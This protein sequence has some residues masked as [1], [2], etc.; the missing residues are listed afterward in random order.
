MR[1]TS[2]AL[3]SA[4]RLD[5]LGR[6]PLSRRQSKTLFHHAG[7]LLLSCNPAVA[8]GSAMGKQSSTHWRRATPHSRQSTPAVSSTFHFR[9]AARVPGLSVSAVQPSAYVARWKRARQLS[10]VSTLPLVCKDE[11]PRVDPQSTGS[12]LRCDLYQVVSRHHHRSQGCHDRAKLSTRLAQK[13]PSLHVAQATSISESYYSNLRVAAAPRETHRQTDYH[14]PGREEPNCSKRFGPR[15]RSA[16]CHQRLVPPA[17]VADQCHSTTIRSRE[18]CHTTTVHHG[19]IPDGVAVQPPIKSTRNARRHKTLATAKRLSSSNT[20]DA[21]GC[22]RSSSLHST[23]S[24]PSSIHTGWPSRSP[25]TALTGSQPSTGRWSFHRVRATGQLNKCGRSFWSVYCLLLFANSPVWNWSRCNPPG[26]FF[27]GGHATGTFGLNHSGDNNDTTSR[28]SVS[29]WRKGCLSNPSMWFSTARVYTLAGKTITHWVDPPASSSHV[30]PVLLPTSDTQSCTLPLASQHASSSEC[31]TFAPATAAHR[32]TGC[33][34]N[35]LFESCTST[36]ST[37]SYYSDWYS[38]MYCDG[39]IC[40]PE[41]S[42][43]FDDSSAGY[44]ADGMPTKSLN[45]S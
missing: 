43:N 34:V 35:S 40:K 39:R 18:S 15:G 22:G 5:S 10:Q 3:D 45:G 30:A 7:Q 32:R 28:L 21:A 23:S 25:S 17:A 27:L 11:A 16:G 37:Q 42:I 19:A 9:P 36:L 33:L 44:R 26:D 8:T 20:S 14:E 4:V 29:Q 12:S 41:N 6:N 13:S 31:Y 2:H 1:K 38:T 24:A